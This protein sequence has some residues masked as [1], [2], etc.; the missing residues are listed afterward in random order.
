MLPGRGSGQE[1]F[2]NRLE[3]RFLRRRFCAVISIRF[4]R[5][6]VAAASVAWFVLAVPAG[7]G[8]DVYSLT[9]EPYG[10]SIANNKALG[11]QLEGIL[12]EHDRT[13]PTGPRDLCMY[14]LL[15]REWLAQRESDSS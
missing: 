13:D 6:A 7:L 12:R 9:S 1:K 11:F 8:D 4:V 2:Q 10:A 14:G 3:D 15:K 5:I